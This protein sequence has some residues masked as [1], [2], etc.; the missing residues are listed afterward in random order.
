MAN[1]EQ[2]QTVALWLWHIPYC[3]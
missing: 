3:E 1:I 2:F